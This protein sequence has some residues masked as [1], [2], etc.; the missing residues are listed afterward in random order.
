MC[1]AGGAPFPVELMARWRRA[2]GLEIH[3][4]YGMSEIG[5]ISG[6]SALSGIRPGSV[7]KPIPGIELQIVD[8]ETGLRI[9]SPGEIGELRVRGPQMSSGYPKRPRKTAQTRRERF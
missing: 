6:A 5:P 2:T 7:G 9:L 8:L 3:D 4:V 1:P